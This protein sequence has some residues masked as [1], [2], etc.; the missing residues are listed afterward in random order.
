[1]CFPICVNG[2]ESYVNIIP[3]SKGGANT[4]EN[5]QILSQNCNLAKRDKIE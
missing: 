3:W 5:I 4:V 1:M 2:Q